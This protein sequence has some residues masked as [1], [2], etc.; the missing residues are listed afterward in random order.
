MDEDQIEAEEI[1]YQEMMEAEVEQHLEKQRIEAELEVF[2]K[3]IINKD[4]NRMKQPVFG[5]DKAGTSLFICEKCGKLMKGPG[6]YDGDYSGDPH[7]S[8]LVLCNE[9]IERIECIEMEKM[10]NEEK[11]ERRNKK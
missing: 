1:A 11:R 6:G 3:G 5:K 8:H 7:H 4:P 10:L 9:C 2:D